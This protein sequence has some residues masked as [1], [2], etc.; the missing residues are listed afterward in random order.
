MARRII[1]RFVRGRLY[2]QIAD[3][4]F[5]TFAEAASAWSAAM[6]NRLDTVE[7]AL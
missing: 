4:L 7:V 5:P 6:A 3:V 2:F 1:P